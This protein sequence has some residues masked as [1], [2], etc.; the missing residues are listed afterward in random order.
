M[1]KLQIM[2][3]TNQIILKNEEMTDLLSNIEPI[4]ILIT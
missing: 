4:L 3:N 1:T 2:R